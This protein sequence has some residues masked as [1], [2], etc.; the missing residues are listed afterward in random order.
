M[1]ASNVLTV[2]FATDKTSSVA[3]KELFG[4]PPQVYFGASGFFE[5]QKQS[6][7]LHYSLAF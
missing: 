6:M 2:R 4:C 7:Q 5:T 3:E 1:S